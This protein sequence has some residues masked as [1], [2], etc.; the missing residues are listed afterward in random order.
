MSA[1]SVTKKEKDAI[2]QTFC[3]DYAEA[4]DDQ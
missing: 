1:T 4:K 3:Q 2:Y